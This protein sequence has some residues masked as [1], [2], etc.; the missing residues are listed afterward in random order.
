MNHACVQLPPG[1]LGDACSE[2]L[3]L[4]RGHVP[5]CRSGKEASVMMAPPCYQKRQIWTLGFA[6]L[7]LTGIPTV[8]T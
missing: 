1:S 7:Y 8:S 5:I 2:A 6:R 4:R 3:E